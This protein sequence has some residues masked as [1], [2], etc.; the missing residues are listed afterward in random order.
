MAG[1]PNSTGTDKPHLEKNSDDPLFWQPSLTY[2][3]A[4]CV[5]LVLGSFA[6][7]ATIYWLAPEQ[8]LRMASALGIGSIGVV[9]GILILRQNP[10]LAAYT[11][12]FG[13]WLA[14]AASASQFGGVR[15]PSVFIFTVSIFFVGWLI[16]PRAAL[17]MGGLTVLVIAFFVFGESAG[18]LPTP[19]ATPALFYGVVQTLVVALG[20]A[21]IIFL[22][23]S[24]GVRSAELGALGATVSSRTAELE[25]RTRDLQRAQAVA[26]TG[27]WI[28]DY[29]AGTVYLSDEACRIFGVPEGTPGNFEKFASSLD[30]ADR[31]LAERTRET[32][33]KTGAG[34]EPHELRLRVRG[35]TRWIRQTAEHE[36][37]PDGRVIRA[38]GTVQDIT[39]RKVTE[40]ALQE[41]EQRYRTL[42]D[43]TPEAVAVH[44]EGLVVYVN[45]AAVAMMGADSAQELLGRRII[46]SVHPDY[47]ALVLTRMKQAGEEGKATPLIE[48][49]FIKLDGTAIDVEVQTTPIVF[50]GRRAIH[51]AM[52]NITARKQVERAL[53]VSEELFSKAFQASPMLI[54]ITTRA[55]GRF[56]NVNDAF[57][58]LLGYAREE[59]IGKTSSDLRI[60]QHPEDRARVIA[61]LSSATV[62]EAS[63]GTEVAVRKKSGA[64][65]LCEVRGASVDLDGVPCLIMV[66]NDITERKAAEAARTSLEAQLRESQK[67]E[68]IGTLAGGIA[69][70]FNNIIATIL[71][72][73][74]LARQD[75]GVNPNLLESLEEIRKSG[76]RAR[77][78][79]QQILSFSRREPTRRVALALP[80]LVQESARLLRATLPARVT[81]EVHCDALVPAV[82]ADATQLQQV[83]INLTTNAMQSMRDR[84]G[85]IALHLDCVML[86]ATMAEAHPALRDLHARH[87]GATVRLAVSDDGEGMEPNTL[88]RVF[89]PFFTTKPVGEGTGLG[90]S[91]VLGIVQTHEG[92]ITVQSQFGAGTTFTVYLPVAPD[93]TTPLAEPRPTGPAPAMPAS[94]GGRHILYVDDDASLVF[95]V[96]R[97]LERRGH[98]VSAYSNQVTALE[99]LRK[100]AAR[101][102]LVLTDYNMPGLSGLDV[103]REVR[104]IRADLPVVVASGFIDDGLR[105]QAAATGVRDVLFKPAVVEDFCSAIEALLGDPEPDSNA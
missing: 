69:H 91:V 19:P 82:L 87:P 64:A 7:A 67:M 80:P 105:S 10:K 26:K 59:V 65:V 29:A 99:A 39:E 8:V 40:I 25:A 66:T 77:E 11:M 58:R 62:S 45:P 101:Y 68:A 21:M 78:L 13:I 35:E 94:H 60:W 63:R 32:A 48:E 79:V 51:V 56:V 18:I 1:Q 14:V 74:E 9:S 50:D 22:V 44:C 96:Q 76:V 90:L 100:D 89:E 57:L 54:S 16:G 3:R 55:E 84:P 88:G 31:A 95:L 75:A 28:A 53:R 93:A 38:I 6:Y 72:N 20:T 73:A 83:L 104:V 37:G 17:S 46:D 92:A 98:R 42:L 61:A 4:A 71:G 102:D 27:S 5:T 15:A 103:A 23:R 2:V 30:P 34:L 43:W 86:D 47:R 70:D 81:L 41:S 52:R 85:H 33:L 24:Y 12:V 49:K 97:L 36:L